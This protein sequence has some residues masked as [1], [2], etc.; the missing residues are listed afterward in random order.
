MSLKKKL[1]FTL[2]VSVIGLALA[3]VVAEV[4]VRQRDTVYATP[5][6]LKNRT[7]EYAPSL[8][9][10]HVFPPKALRAGNEDEVN[11][12]EYYINEKGYRGRDFSTA[13]PEGTIR[14]IFY[15]G[16]AIPSAAPTEANRGE[17]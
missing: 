12:V 2:L 16:S 5:E 15:G 9:A 14:I 17:V 11:P 4:V 8:F 10:R 1:F 6:A 3:L 13:K 7:L